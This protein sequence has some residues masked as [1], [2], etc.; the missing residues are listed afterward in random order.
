MYFPGTH[1]TFT[2]IF[3]N[4]KSYDVIDHLEDHYFFFKMTFKF[5]AQ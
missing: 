1:K 4:G 2:L 5:D 3:L